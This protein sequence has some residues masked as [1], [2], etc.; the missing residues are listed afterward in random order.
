MSFFTYFDLAAGLSASL[1]VPNGTLE[2]IHVHVAEVETA[3]GLETE[4]Y[5]DNPP[6]WKTTKPTKKISAEDY[7]KLAD[8][9]NDWVRRLY[10]HF[11]Q[12]SKNP[13][14]DGEEL[15][16]EQ[17]KTFWHALTFLEVPPEQWTADYYRGRMEHLYEVMRGRESEGVTFDAKALTEKQ[18]A[19]VIRVFDQFLDPDDLRLDVPNGRD[20]LASSSDGGYDW[21]EKCGPMVWEDAMQCRKRGCPL[22]KETGELS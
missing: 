17:A 10:D 6:H 4:Q 13:V 22:R 9:H 21:C 7:C 1:H 16:P 20:Y 11:T 5:L 18:A 14:D 2:A 15:T 8:E 19:A 12:W 3:L